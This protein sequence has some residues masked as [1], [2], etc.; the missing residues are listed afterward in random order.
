MHVEEAAVTKI[1]AETD[2]L[3]QGWQQAMTTFNELKATTFSKVSELGPLFG[4]Q[5][6]DAQQE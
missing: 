5:A 4:Q 3:L 2:A 6:E 1:A